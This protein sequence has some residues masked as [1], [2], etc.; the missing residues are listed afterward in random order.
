MTTSLRRTALGWTTALL[1]AVGALAIV[2]AYIY[3][4]QEAA[5][6]LDGQLRQIAL[7][8]GVD[9]GPA[10]APDA[11]DRDPEDRFAITIWNAQGVVVRRSLPR[12]VIPQGPPGF[13]DAS[14]DGERWR[15]YTLA[16]KGGSVQ[17]AQRETVRTEIAG[18]AA[19]AA[20][21]PILIVIPL[22]WLVVGWAL[23]RVLG[24]LDGLATAIAQRSATTSEP[25]AV[26][27]APSEVAPL[28]ESMNGLIARLRAAVEAQQRF[29]ADAAHELRTPLAAMQI[30]ADN[31]AEGGDERAQ[32][33]SAGV[34]RAGALV[35]QLL[36]LARLDAPQVARLARVGIGETLLDCIADVA[37]LAARRDIDIG[38][39]IAAPA[40]CDAV[41]GD[42]R[43]LLAALI[44]NA[45]RYTGLGGTVDVTLGFEGVRPIVEI[46]DNGAG[47]PQGAEA[48]IFDRFY[49]ADASVA[50][51]SGLGLAI[52]RRIADRYAIGLT[53]ENRADG[54]TGAVARVVFPP[55]T[56]DQQG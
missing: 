23:N 54:V 30:Q 41:E 47:L 1:T 20:A 31:L 33:L 44:D 12:I 9:I 55:L 45:V 26:Y 16:G 15:V 29:V 53:V 8:A 13:S 6:F 4:R 48:R 27:D 19:I 40:A 49:R 24:R 35:D 25:I 43:A 56:P 46:V 37:P 28:I 36:R 32:A 18:S 17:V 7:Y 34:K 11:T 3:A 51:G 10:S 2:I 22:S 14:A 50:E 39:H 52:A 38:A 21:A 5:E 42:V